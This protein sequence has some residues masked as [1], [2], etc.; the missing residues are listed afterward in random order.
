MKKI[1]IMKSLKDILEKPAKNILT[2]SLIMAT[3]SLN[4][5]TKN[6]LLK[7]KEKQLFNLMNFFLVHTAF[8]IIMTKLCAKLF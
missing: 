2:A 1:K 6:V 8:E 4:A 3:Y 5:R 7:K